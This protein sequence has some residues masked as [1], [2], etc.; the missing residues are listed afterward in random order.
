MN[1]MQQSQIMQ[2]L[3]L[4]A[5]SKKKSVCKFK[6]IDINNNNNKK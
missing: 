1:I 3:R 5:I 6:T 2:I 4:A